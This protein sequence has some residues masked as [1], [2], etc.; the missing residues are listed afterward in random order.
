MDLYSQA[1]AAHAYW[2]QVIGVS[3]ARERYG[4]AGLD[5]TCIAGAAPALTGRH[6]ASTP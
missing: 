3:S 2:A 5:R 4:F 6:L 1:K